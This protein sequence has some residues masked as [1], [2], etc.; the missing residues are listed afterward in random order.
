MSIVA[1]WK[2]IVLVLLALSVVLLYQALELSKANT[3]LCEQNL[4]IVTS[5]LDRQNK[6]IKDN[7]QNK[8]ALKEYPTVISKIETRYR[9]VYKT[10]EVIKDSNESCDDII[11]NLNSSSY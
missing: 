2:E 7:E 3:I 5:S 6:A 11:S 4:T 10:V 8:T 1:F 9:T